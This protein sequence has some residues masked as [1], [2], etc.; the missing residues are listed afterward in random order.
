MLSSAPVNVCNLPFPQQLQSQC[1]FACTPFS[2]TTWAATAT[3]LSLSLLGLDAGRQTSNV[4]F[5]L[6]VSGG[7]AQPAHLLCKHTEDDSYHLWQP[8]LRVQS[9]AH[10]PSIC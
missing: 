2:C 4:S 3:S 9:R 5:V 7:L 6:H 8:C 10:H 1:A